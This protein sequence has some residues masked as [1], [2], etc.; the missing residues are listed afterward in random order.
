MADPFKASRAR[1]A[2]LIILAVTLA[3]LAL[4]ATFTAWY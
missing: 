3:G 2:V 4:W 1:S